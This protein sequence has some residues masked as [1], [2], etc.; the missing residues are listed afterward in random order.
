MNHSL[1]IYLNYLNKT[2]VT[3][4]FLNGCLDQFGISTV[5][6]WKNNAY[7]KEY[8]MVRDCRQTAFDF[9]NKICLPN[10]FLLVLPPLTG[11]FQFQN[12]IKFL[13]HMYKM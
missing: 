8:V 1:N 3:A 10:V 11:R 5:V 13:G 6:I 2:F 12:I 9:L 4:N 7:C